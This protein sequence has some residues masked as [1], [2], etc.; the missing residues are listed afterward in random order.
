MI[1]KELDFFSAIEPEILEFRNNL[2]HKQYD[3]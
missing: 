2:F 1:A 3:Y